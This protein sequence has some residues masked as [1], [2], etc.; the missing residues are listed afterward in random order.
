MGSWVYVCVRTFQTVHFKYVQVI[1]CLLYLSK[2]VF[3]NN[4]TRKWSQERVH[5][6]NSI[7]DNSKTKKHCYYLLTQL[8]KGSFILNGYVLTLRL[9]LFSFGDG[10]R[11]GEG[12][13]EKHQLVAFRTPPTGNQAQNPSI[14]PE[15]KLNQRPFGSQVSTQS[16]EPHQP[17]LKFLKVPPEE[18]S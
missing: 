11:E 5:W 6:I 16:T 2:A 4:T 3:K 13:G 10:G 15:W 9:Y 17:E 1:A 8:P 14:C 12:E 18:L 7:K